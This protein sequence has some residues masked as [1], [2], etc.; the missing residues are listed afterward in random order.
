[1]KRL[2]LTVPEPC[3]ENWT[4]MTP[5]EKGRFCAACQKNVYDFT[6]STDREIINAY[7]KDKNYAGVF[8]THN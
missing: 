4:E 3:H 7:E 6:K 8:S 2:H 1:M 5:I